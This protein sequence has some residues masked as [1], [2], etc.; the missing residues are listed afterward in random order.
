MRRPLPSPRLIP[1]FKVSVEG[2]LPSS[3]AMT[4]RGPLTFVRRKSYSS[5]TEAVLKPRPTYTALI[6]R[7]RNRGTF[8]AT[9]V[10][11]VIV[12]FEG[13]RSALV[14]IGRG[15][16]FV[17]LLLLVIVDLLASG[18]RDLWDGLVAGRGNNGRWIR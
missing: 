18:L 6:N 2:W 14:E 12:L 7:P 9:F 5:P 1:L 4:V 8:R 3:V 15:P 16:W 10:V 11:Y 17:D 13:T